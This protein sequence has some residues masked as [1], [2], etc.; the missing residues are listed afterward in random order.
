MNGVLHSWNEKFLASL[1]VFR[2]FNT[3]TL[4]MTLAKKTSYFLVL[5]IKL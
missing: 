1:L 2:I 4:L 5:L 3:F